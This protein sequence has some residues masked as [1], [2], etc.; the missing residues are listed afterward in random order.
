MYVPKMAKN[1]YLHC[2]EIYA[3]NDGKTPEFQLGD[4]IT[5]QLT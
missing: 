4:N 2:S 3:H 5:P 1:R